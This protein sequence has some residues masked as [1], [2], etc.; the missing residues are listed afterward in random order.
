MPVSS[1]QLDLPKLTTLTARDV[2]GYSE[3][4]DYPERVVLESDSAQSGMRSRH[5]QSLLGSASRER[6]R[7]L[8]RDSVFEWASCGVSVV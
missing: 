2:N 8:H 1:D 7:V 3:T 6:V 5:A 4:F